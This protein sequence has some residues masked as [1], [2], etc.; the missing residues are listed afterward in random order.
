[1]ARRPM[2][3]T[4]LLNYGDPSDTVQ[5]LASLETSTHLDQRLFVV[6]NGPDD[7]RHATL[8]SLVGDRARVIATGENLGYAAGNNVGIREALADRPDFVWIVNP[9]T[10]AEP[11]TLERLLEGAEEVGD[12]GIVGAR[13]VYPGQPP[14]LWFDGGVVD[15]TRYGATHHDGVGQTE[16][17]RPAPET[18]EV[19]YVTGAC[20]LVRRQVLERVGLLPEEWFLY[21]EETDFCLRTQAAGFRAVVARR[22][23]MVHHKRS[24]GHLP[25]ASYLYY[26]TRNRLRFGEIHGGG[27]LDDVL[28]DFRGQFLAPWRGRVE[29]RAGDWLPVFDE[30]VSRAVQDAR[31]GV[32]GRQPAVE[33]APGPQRLTDPTSQTPLENSL[34]RE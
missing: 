33:R 4:V 16:R 34:E 15:R 18:V 8:A 32:T 26:M 5:C 3:A 6:D 14:R 28:T 10:E 12:A 11:T 21:F 22:A 13:I 27:A 24:S 7:E 20:L 9:D 2:V 25:T 1:M 23:R 19:D 29:Q 31:D 17:Q 30:L